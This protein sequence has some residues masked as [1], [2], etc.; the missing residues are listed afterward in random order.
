V[1]RDPEE[2]KA[3]IHAHA[4]EC[5]ES[6]SSHAVRRGSITHHLTSDIP[7]EV[8]SAR[9]NV[10]KRVLDMHYDQRSERTKMEQRRR[11]LHKL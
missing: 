5:P 3:A 4:S 1:D 9:A 11:Y 10:E 7:V 2:C 6:V 8:V